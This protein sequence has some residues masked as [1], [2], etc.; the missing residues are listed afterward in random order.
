ML[1]K[2]ATGIYVLCL[3]AWFCLALLLCITMIGHGWSAVG[4]KLLHVA[5]NTN[6]FGVESWSLVVWRFLGLLAI[7]IAAGYFRGARR[8]SS[9]GACR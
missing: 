3:A 4:S 1:R 8:L 9:V 5:G 7:T 6:E 2:I